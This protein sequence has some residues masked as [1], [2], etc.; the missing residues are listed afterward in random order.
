MI[1]HLARAAYELQLKRTGRKPAE[2][3]LLS[4]PAINTEEVLHYNKNVRPSP[5]KV[6]W[7]NQAPVA[8]TQEEHARFQMAVDKVGTSDPAKIAKLMGSRNEAQVRAYM[9]NASEIE[10]G[11]AAIEQEMLEDTPRK[12]GG[13]GRK[14]PTTAMNTVPN[15][16]LDAKSMLQNLGKKGS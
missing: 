8:W 4:S 1:E 9:K 11:A 7:K 15:A 3:G 14:P 12:R 2:D 6:G 13:R 5:K 10:K 16:N